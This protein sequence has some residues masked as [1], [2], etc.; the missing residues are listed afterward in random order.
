MDP[1]VHNSLRLCLLLEDAANADHIKE[2]HSIALRRVM[3]CKCTPEDIR[4]DV[5]QTVL[6]KYAADNYR[7]C[8]TSNPMLSS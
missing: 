5:Q 7:V 8:V 2:N 3:N 1:I 4:S 6:P